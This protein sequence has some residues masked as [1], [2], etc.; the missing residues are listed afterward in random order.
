MAILIFIAIFLGFTVAV[1]SVTFIVRT[2][3]R[4][5]LQ[6]EEKVYPLSVEKKL[7]QISQAIEA[8]ASPADLLAAED[9]FKALQREYNEKIPAYLGLQ[10]MIDYKK[11]DYKHSE[12][13]LEKLIE[14]NKFDFCF[15][16]TQ[17]IKL[18]AE[19]YLAQ[20]FHQKAYDEYSALL[21][22]LPNDL[23]CFYQLGWLMKQMDNESEAQRY[24]NKVLL[25]EPSHA[26]ALYEMGKIFYESN[27]FQDAMNY[28][29][30]SIINGQ[31]GPEVNF[32]LGQAV[33]QLGMQYTLG[34]EALERCSQSPDWRKEALPLLMQIYFQL[35]MPEKVLEKGQLY[36]NSYSNDPKGEDIIKVEILMANALEQENNYEAAYAGWKNIHKKAP[37]NAELI[38]KINRY[39]PLL[40]NPVSLLYLNS[41]LDNFLRLCLHYCRFMSKRLAKGRPIHLQVFPREYGCIIMET[42]EKQNNP[43]MNM[44]HS[45]APISHLFFRYNEPI[46]Q[47]HLNS[48][49]KFIRDH[50][51]HRSFNFYINLYSLNEYSEE[52][53]QE[54]KSITQIK[55]THIYFL[56][57]KEFLDL[58]SQAPVPQ[59]LAETK[60]TEGNTV[61]VENKSL[62]I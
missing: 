62:G 58:L 59:N 1:T 21:R 29:N 22:K 26:R 53:V 38:E 10:A 56:K 13:N 50:S 61:N 17:C 27:L 37:N 47:Q 15:S 49:F 41:D 2:Q 8:A 32:L 33:L 23:E 12:E 45:D 34:A 7:R 54:I 35:K 57:G 60:Y 43:S 55:E 18:R 31:Q 52:F 3:S 51:T 5:G 16:E 9:S 39:E 46:T 11:G 25:D 6:G 28:L 24:F 30:K 20:G 44:Y 14:D 19:I 40:E 48:H 42:F 36:L 4:K